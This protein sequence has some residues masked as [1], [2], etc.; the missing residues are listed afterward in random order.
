MIIESCILLPLTTI[1]II[2]D[3]QGC[4]IRVRDVFPIRPERTKGCVRGWW[5]FEAIP[6]S[7]NIWHTPTHYHKMKKECKTL[8]QLAMQNF[9]FH[10]DVS[11]RITVQFAYKTYP[12]GYTE[13]YEFCPGT[14]L[15]TFQRTCTE[16]ELKELLEWNK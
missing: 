14:K 13:V 7:N 6:P 11:R 2:R 10:A 12:K 4:R 3:L 15:W 9:H 5:G 8:E 16:F 1:I